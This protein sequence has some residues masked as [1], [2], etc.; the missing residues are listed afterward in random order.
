DFLERIV[1]AWSDASEQARVSGIARDVVML[2][3]GSQSNLPAALGWTLVDLLQRP[4]LLARVRAGDE[5]LVERC[6]SESIRLAQR[7]ITLRVVRQPVRLDD[8]KRTYACA[9]GV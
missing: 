9:P 2:H 4:A 1:A 6:A 7:S 3:M 8:G 5:A